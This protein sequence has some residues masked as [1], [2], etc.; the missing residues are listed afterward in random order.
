M[1]EKTRILVVEDDPELLEALQEFLMRKGYSVDIARDVTQALIKLWTGRY[2]IAVTD[3]VM[4][5]LSGLKLL[6]LSKGI[7]DVIDFIVITG[8]DSPEN[9]QEAIR[10]G[11][12]SYFVKPFDL[13]EVLRSIQAITSIRNP[14]NPS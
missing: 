3:I 11:A 6:S 10:L 8:Y 13:D 12:K 2:D 4:P 14:E 5:G 1:N 9:R 7:L